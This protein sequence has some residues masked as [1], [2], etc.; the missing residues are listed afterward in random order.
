M[1]T[2]THSSDFRSPS[3]EILDELIT[4]LGKGTCP[5]TL[6]AIGHRKI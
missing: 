2:Y 4:V 5:D 6:R 3:V 1:G